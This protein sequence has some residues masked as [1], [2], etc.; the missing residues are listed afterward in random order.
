MLTSGGG[1]STQMP[2][3]P[4]CHRWKEIN[5]V[6]HRFRRGNAAASEAQTRLRPSETPERKHASEA[7]T[8]HRHSEMP[9]RKQASE[10]QTSHRHS[11]MPERNR[12]R[13]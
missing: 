9:E 6:R 3:T 4:S 1:I 13:K 10:A 5:L 2:A 8:S 12:Q 7:Q 11:E